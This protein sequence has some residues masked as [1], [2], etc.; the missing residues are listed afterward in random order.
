MPPQNRFPCTIRCPTP[1]G[2]YP[3]PTQRYRS[4]ARV[5]GRPRAGL[6]APLAYLSRQLFPRSRKLRASFST[7]GEKAC[8]FRQRQCSREAVDHDANHGAIAEPVLVLPRG[9]HFRE[10][11][12]RGVHVIPGLCACRIDIHPRLE[13]TWVIQ[14]GRHDDHKV[15]RERRQAEE[16]R[17]AT[18]AETS[19]C[20]LA[21]I[22]FR[23]GPEPENPA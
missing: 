10:L 14:T 16:S 23:L 7:I 13:Y 2:V 21:T 19:F 4:E 11:R 22:G 12:Q 8:P 20:Q 18:R 9:R 3:R 15:G 6:S 5:R 1:G 17:P